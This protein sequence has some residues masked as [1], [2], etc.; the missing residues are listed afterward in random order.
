MST[1]ALAY[2]IVMG[3][4]QQPNEPFNV[5]P[6]IIILSS[7]NVGAMNNMILDQTL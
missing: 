4:D 6:C 2:F 3:Y 7:E 1:I 5:L